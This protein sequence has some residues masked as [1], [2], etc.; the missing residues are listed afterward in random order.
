M[1]EQRTSLV[2]P[3]SVIFEQHPDTGRDKK[4]IRLPEWSTW[5]C[6]FDSRPARQSD[7]STGPDPAIRARTVLQGFALPHNFVE[8]FQN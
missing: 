6:R 5:F 8:C 7:I 1:A 3:S 2:K 4:H